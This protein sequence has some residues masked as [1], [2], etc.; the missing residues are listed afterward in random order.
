MQLLKN[1]SKQ[2]NKVEFENILL[3]LDLLDN[4]M[5]SLKVRK[6]DKKRDRRILW[7][8]PNTIH[9]LIYSVSGY[10]SDVV[11]AY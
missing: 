6:E 5:T 7:D 11:N 8:P 1:I 2:E 10:F 9:N 4:K 3:N